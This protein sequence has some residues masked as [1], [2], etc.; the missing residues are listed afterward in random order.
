MIIS[1]KHKFIFI[2]TMKTAGSSLEIHLSKFCG[3]KDVFTSM[4]YENHSGQNCRSYFNPIADIGE[5]GLKEAFKNLKRKRRYYNHMPAWLIKDR[6]GK[7]IWDNYFKFC[8]E[9]NP[10]DKTVSHYYWRKHRTP[11]SLDDYFK[12]GDFCINYPLYTDRETQSAMILDF[13]GKY[14]TMEAD[15]KHVCDQIGIP[16]EGALNVRAKSGI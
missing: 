3:S 13:V 12:K 6:I 1:H 4:S 8:F 2:K 11:M 15:I 5:F 16:H 14:E 9:R 10:W 7:N